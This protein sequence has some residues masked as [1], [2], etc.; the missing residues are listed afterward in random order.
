MPKNNKLVPEEKIQKLL[1]T[2]VD[3][4]DKED[5]DVRER[6]IR[7]CKQLKLFWD[8]IFQHWYSEVAHDWRVWDS[9]LSPEGDSDQAY[10]DKPINTFRPLIETIIAALSVTTPA[11]KCYP[12]DAENSL[13]TVTAKAGDKISRLIDNHNNS[14]LLWLRAIFTYYTEGTVYGYTYPRTDAKYGDYKTPNYEENKEI[15][16]TQICPQC[17]SEEPVEDESIAADSGIA[18]PPASP[19]LMEPEEIPE[20]DDAYMPEEQPDL[21]SKCGNQVVMQPGMK[22]FITTKFVGNT[23]NPKTRV[24]MEVYGGLYV[25]IANYAKIAE[26]TPY[27][28]FAKE[29]HYAV[30]M[31]EYEHL[32]GNDKLRQKLK[33]G[34][35]A[36]PRDDYAQWGRMNT[37]YLGEYPNY[38]VT[39]RKVWLRPCA[40]NVIGNDEDIKELKKLYPRGVKVCLVNDEFGSAEDQ[41]LDDYWTISVNPQEDFLAHDPAGIPLVTQQ[42]IVNDII[43]L[44]LQTMEHGIGQTFADPG[45]LNF[46]AYK[47]TETTP[48]GVY[49]AV[50]KGGK[51]VSDAFYQLK[52]ATMSAEVMP[53]FEQVKGLGQFVSGA[54]PS[55]FG[56]QLDGS[57][58]ASEYSMSQA[59]ARQ[60]IQNL[61]KLFTHWWKELKGKAIPIYI[62]KMKWDET[63]VQRMPDGSFINLFIRMSELN[64]KIGKIELE[65]ADNLPMTW[66]QNKDT[67][68]KLIEAQN[69]VF[70]EMFA[71]PENIPILK[72]A[73]GLTDFYIP[74][75]DDRMKQNDEIRELLA[76]EPIQNPMMGEMGPDGQPVQPGMEQEQQMDPGA[77]QPFMPS[78]EIDTTYDNHKV[79]FEIVRQWAT[80]E[81][82]R[83]AKIENQAG[84]QNVLLHG[85][86]H[87]FEMN[88]QMILEQA[89][90][91]GGASKGQDN[92]EK[93]KGSKEIK[94]EADVPV[95]Q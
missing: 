34:S 43:S 93:P 92:P 90:E 5:R 68:M 11:A 74:G 56:G 20:I 21:C 51:S 95:K 57:N 89:T 71:A 6:Q 72:D 22:T 52:T 18:E 9:N 80:S 29:V 55:L 4:F 73:I 37:L 36:G 14:P 85:Q 69:P 76:S 3:E 7:K 63:D 2:V 26:D 60:R 70:L 42:D 33:L 50:P 32:R 84:Y 81:A 78:V 19:E 91:S 30:A 83:L 35:T 24:C 17:G 65:A 40:F 58:T 62:N 46:K 38:V 8:S 88:K 59:N 12:A 1:L 77:S 10:Y 94:G 61:Y 15:K 82:G 45:V 87:F 16:K 25:K 53:F 79:Q 28:I 27:L 31:E 23:T 75:E 64:G 39:I 49:E 41:A 66:T 67:I 54:M 86:M 13:D 48:G 44:T 47:D